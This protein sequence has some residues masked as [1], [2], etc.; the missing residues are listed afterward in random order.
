MGEGKPRGHKRGVCDV[1]RPRADVEWAGAGGVGISPVEGSERY[2][3]RKASG[4]AFVI[5]FL[6]V[7]IGRF[8]YGV[9]DLLKSI[10][11][12]HLQRTASNEN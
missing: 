8:G 11:I 5:T 1:L 9:G 2:R 10:S 7:V 12:I 6:G 4:W 3:K